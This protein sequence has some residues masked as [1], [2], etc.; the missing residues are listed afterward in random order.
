MNMD[1]DSLRRALRATKISN[2][3]NIFQNLVVKNS[4]SDPKISLLGIDEK[5]YAKICSH[6]T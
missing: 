6:H 5:K 3:R 4:V 2:N 1:L